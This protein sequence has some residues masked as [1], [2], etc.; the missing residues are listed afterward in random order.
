M[1]IFYVKNRLQPIKDSTS[2]SRKGNKFMMTNDLVKK[3]VEF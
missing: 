2:K 3:H 1:H